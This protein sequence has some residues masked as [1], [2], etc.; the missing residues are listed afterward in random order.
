MPPIT[1]TDAAIA[2]PAVRGAQACGRIARTGAAP[3]SRWY[4]V[5]TK[6]SCETRAAFHLERQSYR[7]FFPR[8][9]KQVRH[10]RVTRRVFEPLF[11]TYL[12]VHLDPARE[13]WRSINGTHGVVGL[14]MQGE[15]P[16]AG[17]PRGGRNHRGA[18]RR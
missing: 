9:G 14:V 8:I 7:V 11:P 3:D 13:P 10:A 2:A 1:M 18:G 15:R 12:F 4:V 5:H 17:P 6:P 16:A